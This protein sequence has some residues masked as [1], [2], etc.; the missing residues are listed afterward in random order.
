MTRGEP[1]AVA[2]KLR[3]VFAKTATPLTP[4][5][6]KP[7]AAEWRSIDAILGTHAE[8]SG[9]VAEY[10]FPRKER[11]RVHAMPVES[12]G[13]LETASEVVFQQL[14]N[15]RVA[16]GG[17]LFV[18]PSEVDPVV[19]VLDEHGLSVTAVHNHMVDDLPR[20]YWIHWY[21]TGDGPTLARGVA[22]ALAHMNGAQKSR[23][24]E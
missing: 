3:A 22:A 10:E 2:K 4:E 1:E 7:S 6:E 20:M 9:R 14:G 24:E 17:E 23:A 12:T 16:C 15:G 13:M 21:A 18:E 19:R 8:A 5:R 11:L